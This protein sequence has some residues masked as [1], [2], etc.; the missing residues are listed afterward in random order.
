M[1]EVTTATFDLEDIRSYR[2]AVRSRCHSAASTVDYPRI[3]VDFE[4]TKPND[5]L[6]STNIP[7]EWIYHT[8]EEEIAYGP[9]SWLLVSVTH[10]NFRPNE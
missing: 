10:I 8:P 9:A 4:L 3:F 7:M 2:I 6:T 1:Q 5:L